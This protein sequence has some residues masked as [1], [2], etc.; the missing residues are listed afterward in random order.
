MKN[1]IFYVIAVVALALTVASCNT[2]YDNYDAPSIVFEGQLK[3]VEGDN[4]QFDASKDLFVFY[5]SGY[6]KTDVGTAM[7]T[8]ND[9][10][11]RQL[12]FT[13]DYTLTLKNNKYPFTIDEFPTNSDGQGFDSIQYHISKD[14]MTNFTVRPFYKVTNLD[15]VYNAE[16]KQIEATFTVKRLVDDAPALKRAYLYLGTSVNVNSA[17]KCTRLTTLHPTSEEEQ[18]FTAKIPV[19]YYRNKNYGMIN[20]FRTY[21]YY[22]IGLMVNGYNDYY[23]FSETKK[24]E[25]LNDLE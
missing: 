20:N 19:S 4:F 1:K 3:D 8:D 10:K 22:R 12:L 15:A 16:T 9:G 6:G 21:A 5:Q 17:N 23:L 24:I 14:V 13:G 11:F 7:N 2:E 25:G 18:T